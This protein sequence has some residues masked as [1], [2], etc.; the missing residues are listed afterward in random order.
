MDSRFYIQYSGEMDYDYDAEVYNLDLFDTPIQIIEQ[1]H[2]R[3]VQV[4]CYFSAGTIEDWRP[5]VEDFPEEVIGEAL[6]DW[7]G[8][9]WLDISNLEALAPIMTARMDLAVEKGCDGVDPDNVNGYTQNS[10]FSL[11]AE[12]QLIYNHWLAEQAHVRGL[13]IGL[14]ND[15]EQIPTLVGIFDFALNEECFAYDECGLLLPFVQLGKPVLGIE[16][17]DKP[18]DFCPQANQMGFQ[19]ILKHKNLDAFQVNCW[20]E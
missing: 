1:L 19:T 12:D 5:D 2:Q 14:K 13:A 4:I 8:E 15:L 10:G 16:Y 18:E 6:K 3:G 7:E 11:T 20:D 9:S 17:G